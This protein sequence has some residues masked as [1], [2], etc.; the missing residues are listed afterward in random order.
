MCAQRLVYPRMSHLYNN[1]PIQVYSSIFRVLGIDY[2][3][4]YPESGLACTEKSSPLKVV[5]SVVGSLEVP[6]RPIYY[7]PN[8]FNNTCTNLYTILFIL[9]YSQA[10]TTQQNKSA[11]GRTA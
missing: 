8:P 11:K 3:L 2:P 1:Y 9:Q 7:T 5:G 10:C 4:V 6:I